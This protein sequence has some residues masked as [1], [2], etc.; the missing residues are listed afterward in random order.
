MVNELEQL[1]QSYGKDRTQLWLRNYE[2][3]DYEAAK[4]L[5]YVGYDLKRYVPTYE[6]VEFFLEQIGNPPSIKTK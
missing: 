4:L 3:M 1:P 5:S 6:N 2:S